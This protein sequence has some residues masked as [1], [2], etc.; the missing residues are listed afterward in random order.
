MSNARTYQDQRRWR[1]AADK[2][3]DAR[4][5]LFDCAGNLTVTLPL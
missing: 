4:K 3:E 2:A 5:H 1:A